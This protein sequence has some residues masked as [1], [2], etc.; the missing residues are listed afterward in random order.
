MIE[1]I[2]QP[3]LRNGTYFK[4]SGMDAAVDAGMDTVPMV[5][6]S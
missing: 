2:F 3:S 5:G 4:C 1:S 6:D